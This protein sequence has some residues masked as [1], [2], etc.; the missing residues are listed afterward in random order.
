MHIKQLPGRLRALLSALPKPHKPSR[1][2][3]FLLLVSFA[4]AVLIW[5]LIVPDMKP[6]YTD[7]PVIAD[8]TD[9]KAEDYDLQLLPESEA[10]LAELKVAADIVGNRTAIGGLSKKDLV[11]YVDFDDVR[12]DVGEQT[13]RL[14]LRNTATNKDVESNLVE[15]KLSPDTV[16]VSLDHYTKKNVPVSKII[17]RPNIT[18]QD[19]ETLINEEGITVDPA[20]VIVRGPSTKLDQ[21]D[22]VCLTL[23]E[24]AVLR[25]TTNF[26][27]ISE[28]TLMDSNG[29][30]IDNS[31]GYYAV[32]EPHFTVTI[33]VYYRISLPVTGIIPDIEKDDPND[34]QDDAF[35]KFIYDRIRLNGSY[36][37]PGYGDED[38]ENLIITIRTLNQTQKETLDTEKGI[39]CF[40]TL[41]NA[42]SVDPQNP[43]EQEISLP[44]GMENI[45]EYDTIFITIDTDGLEKRDCW[46]K[47]SD[48]DMLRKLPGF[49][50]QPDMPGGTTPVTLIGPPEELA[51][52][53]DED[54]K[55]SVDLM[56]I[57]KTEAGL[58][59]VPLT[60][61]LP[62][63]VSNVWV[64]AQPKVDIYIT[65]T[66][67]T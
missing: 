49:T 58:K 4:A 25:E 39:E 48:I 8:L 7:I 43:S 41:L 5:A 56:S 42:V 15:V 1:A 51:K 45:S 63:G 26:D 11:A 30:A 13:L 66:K 47:N 2:N 27:S 22:H 12:K 38:A 10:A 31:L 36:T 17:E 24:K 60:V 64:T 23:S 29:N 33:P 61:K 40:N 44:E 14:R 46:I 35:R 54:L 53:T 20:T 3:L 28:C 55:L 37:L 34:T 52:F 32:Q 57:G 59:S 19:Q 67:T 16:P 50:Y 21:I 62:Q 9:T 6:H 65:E 18:T